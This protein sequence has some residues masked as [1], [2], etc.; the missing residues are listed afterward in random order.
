MLIHSKLKKLIWGTLEDYAD[1]YVLECK[2]HQYICVVNL[3]DEGEFAGIRSGLEQL[4]ET[5]RYDAVYCSVH[6]N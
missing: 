3:D 2:Q 5:F 1:L 4:E 6:A